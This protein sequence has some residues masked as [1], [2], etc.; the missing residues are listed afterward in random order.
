M[1]F[2]AYVSSPRPSERVHTFASRAAA[3]QFMDEAEADGALAGFPF[4]SNSVWA[5]R[6]VVWG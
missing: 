4:W 5:V 6:V 3:W 1:N 2:A